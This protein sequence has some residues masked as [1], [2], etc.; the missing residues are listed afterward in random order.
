MSSHDLS[1]ANADDLPEIDGQ[2]LDEE[3]P[4][5]LAAAASPAAPATGDFDLRGSLGGDQGFDLG[6]DD[7]MP[8]LP[9][10]G[11]SNGFVALTSAALPN[12]GA[13]ASALP[14]TA[15]LGPLPSLPS[16]TSPPAG[17]APMAELTELEAAPII[18]AA[19]VHQEPAADLSALAAEAPKSSQENLGDLLGEMDFDLP[20][21]PAAGGLAAAAPAKPVSALVAPA[22]AT[23]S[24]ASSPS[25]SPAVPS[26]AKP[27]S[28]SFGAFKAAGNPFS[29]TAAAPVLAAPAPPIA[30]APIAAVP[31]AAVPVAAVPVAAVA[32][33][34]AAAIVSPAVGQHA[35]A[36]LSALGLDIGASIADAITAPS[37]PS[38]NPARAALVAA[39][40]S[41]VA[42]TVLPQ[43]AD[44]VVWNLARVLVAKGLVS[45]DDLL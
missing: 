42:A 27:G 2:P 23:S 13:G 11:V 16:F 9:T 43:G 3:A 18:P 6:G 5:A 40:R 41:P 33:P 24:F 17:P 14:G 7:P 30:A 29:K 44:L 4:D 15:A 19:P 26:T 34:A 31:V 25:P 12:Q 38:S 20:P 22:L 8:G 10:G 1:L 32:P 36:P 39:L 37:D 35:A 21:P 45:I 28:P